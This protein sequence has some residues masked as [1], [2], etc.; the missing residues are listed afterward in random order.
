MSATKSDYGPLY[1]STFKAHFKEDVGL[2]IGHYHANSFGTALNLQIHQINGWNPKSFIQK[3]V[4]GPDHLHGMWI[5]KTAL[6]A[7]GGD[8]FS[9]MSKAAEAVDMTTQEQYKSRIVVNLLPKTPE[10]STSKCV[11]LFLTIECNLHLTIL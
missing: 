4:E 1:V 10:V 11:C 7:F 5:A 3:I 2:S 9:N 8:H 6:I